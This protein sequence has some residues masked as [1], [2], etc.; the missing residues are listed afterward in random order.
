MKSKLKRKIS[1]SSILDIKIVYGSEHIRFNLA[2]E[3]VINENK[4]NEELKH[5]PSYYGFLRLLMNKLDRV[6]NDK[7][8]EL[9]KV[10]SSLF[11]NNKDDIDPNTSRPYNNDIAEAKVLEDEE[12]LEAINNY[13][14]ALE[15]YNI[16]ETCV[17]SFEQRSRIIQSISAN[18][19]DEKN[20][21]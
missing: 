1:V 5:Q 20:N 3:L 6:K 21:F 7:K 9:D 14:K 10:F 8:V 19:R 12:Y 18:L 13:N 11:I 17:Q 4:I 15:D 16:I 2:E